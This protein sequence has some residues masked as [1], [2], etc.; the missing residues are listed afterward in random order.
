MFYLG[1]RLKKSAGCGAHTVMR[2]SLQV[3]TDSQHFDGVSVGPNGSV[4]EILKG[5][6]YC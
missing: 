4:I 3:G 2:F 6:R 5:T 1:E